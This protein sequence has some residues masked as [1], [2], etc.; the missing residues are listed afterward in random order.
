ML[1]VAAVLDL[2]EGVVDVQHNVMQ[3]RRPLSHF[4]LNR[5]AFCAISSL[6]SPRRPRWRLYQRKQYAPASKRIG[7]RFNHVVGIFTLRHGFYAPLAKS[8]RARR[9]RPV[10][11]ASRMRERYHHLGRYFQIRVKAKLAGVVSDAT[12]TGSFNFTQ[13][14]PAS[15]A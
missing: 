4:Q 8:V 1:I 14:A 10:R 7:L 3:T 5:A 15:L 11:S 13:N 2:P 9:Q 6:M 12:V